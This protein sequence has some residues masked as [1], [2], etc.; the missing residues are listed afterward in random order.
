MKKFLFF[1]LPGLIFAAIYFGRIFYKQYQEDREHQEW[2][3]NAEDT[4]SEN[5]TVLKD[6]I[7]IDYQNE[8][9]TVHLYLPPG[10]FEDS[11]T[12]PV[13]Y[14]LDGD[15]SFS[16]LVSQAPEWQV[17]EVIDSTVAAGG[18]AAIVIGIP[19]AEDRDAEYTP[20]VNDDNPDAHGEAFIDWLVNDFKPWVDTN[21]RTQPARAATG[22][23]G[24][25][26]SGMMAYYTM[27]SHPETFGIGLIQSPSM[28]V[29][30]ERLLAMDDPANG[31]G[32]DTR[33]F[34]S[35][36]ELE[37][38]MVPQ[39]QGVYDKFAAAGL[40]KDDQLRMH[41]FEGLGHWHLTWRKSFRMAYPWIVEEA[42]D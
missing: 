40:R 21:F 35:V 23:G 36:G 41:V 1:L 17:D 4:A 3:A 19:S 10:Y 32:E 26:R 11:I 34:V 18:P 9:R 13:I 30:E 39:A 6:S 27:M 37:A 33:V 5:V 29:D 31:W 8:K 2:L 25:S 15:G 12:Y 16:D 42:N 22:V 28:W 24:I 38:P 14:M 20:W 7:L